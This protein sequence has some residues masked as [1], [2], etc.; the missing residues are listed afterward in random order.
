MVW[1]QR[2]LQNGREPDGEHKLWEKKHIKLVTCNKMEG[3]M[4]LINPSQLDSEK[5]TDSE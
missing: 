4:I 5:D 2:C 1:I 3:F